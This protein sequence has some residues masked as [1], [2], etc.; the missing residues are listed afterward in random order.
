MED[1]KT[2]KHYLVNTLKKTLV[3]ARLFDFTKRNSANINDLILVEIKKGC[4]T[5]GWTEATPCP[6][7]SSRQQAGLNGVSTFL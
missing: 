1:W 4:V 2:L 5:E 6:V 7:R 3:L